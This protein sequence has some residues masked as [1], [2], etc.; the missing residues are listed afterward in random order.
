METKV[1]YKIAS[2]YYLIGNLFNKGFAFLTVPIF[3]RILSTEDYGLVTTY[4]SWVSMLS[5][6]L[7]CA[8]HMGIRMAFVDYKNKEH[9]FLSVC[10]SFNIIVTAVTLVITLL[11]VSVINIDVNIQILV[12]CILH[13]FATGVILNFTQ[14]QMMKYKY[15]SRTF[16]LVMP[17]FLSIIVSLYFIIFVFDNNLYLG[18]IIPTALIHLFFAL[19]II[20]L[21]FKQSRELF[22][23]EYLLY[24]LKISAPLII[25]GI[26]LN[27]L[28][29]SDRVMITA[30][31]G[32][33]QTGIYSLVYNF[34]MLAQVITVT[35]EGIWVP[36]FISKLEKSDR[37][38]IKKMSVL[39]MKLITCLI[40]GITIMGPEIIKIF[41]DS[42]YWGGIVIIPPIV[43][44][45]YVLFMY[46]MY[47][48]VEH[49]Y[50][51]TVYITI[52][53]LISAAINLILNFI[54]IPMY[55]YVAAAFTTLFA[56][57]VSFFL[58][59]HHAKKLEPDLYPLKMFAL[60]FAQ[61]LI[62]IIIFYVFNEQLLL[63]ISALAV[64]LC[65]MLVSNKTEIKEV[66][67]NRNKI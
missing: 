2:L 48:N 15:K 11:V 65:Y 3:S 12:L 13:S 45:S 20:F 8:I 53:T 28:S 34:G 14:Y 32:A 36:W 5:L 9:D 60:P 6:V 26:G 23:K 4:N 57:I 52:N 29:Q 63:R 31:V 46:S 18:R 16:L 37:D 62:M 56:Y 7:S 50:K 19:V 54:F 58:H 22:N 64:Y 49:Y 51:D 59:S 35:L 21:I 41:A 17:S 33:K 30:L 1:N 42:R 10:T 67:L 25:H 61:V 44:A 24:A 38:S 47:V 40:I 27:I 39:Y 55:G 66:L 43:L